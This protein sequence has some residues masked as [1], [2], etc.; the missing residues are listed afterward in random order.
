MQTRIINTHRKLKWGVA[1]VDHPFL[2]VLAE[3][4]D[5]KSGLGAEHSKRSL[6]VAVAATAAASLKHQKMLKHFA[7]VVSREQS[8]RQRGSQ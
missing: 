8:S 5:K 4:R 2:Q 6:G 1:Y 3:V 7:Q